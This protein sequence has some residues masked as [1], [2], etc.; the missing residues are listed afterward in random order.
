MEQTRLTA[1]G[2]ILGR[3]QLSIETRCRSL[4]AA[5]ATLRFGRDDGAWELERFKKQIPFGN[6]RKKNND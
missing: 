4:S 2:R 6:D 5:R 1:Q 3:G